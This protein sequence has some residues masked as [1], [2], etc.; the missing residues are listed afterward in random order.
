MV[1]ER[2]GHLHHIGPHGEAPGLVRK[3]KAGGENVHRRLYHCSCIKEM[4]EAGLV[5]LGL[6]SL[7]NFNSLWGALALSSYLGLWYLALE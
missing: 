6:A 2:R 3:Q 1:P 5:S 4:C 7:N